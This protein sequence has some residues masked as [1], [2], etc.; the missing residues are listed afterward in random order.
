ME[1]HVYSAKNLER[2]KL[3]LQ[4]NAKETIKEKYKLTL[5]L[6]PRLITIIAMIKFNIATIKRVLFFKVKFI[7]ISIIFYIIYLGKLSPSKYIAVIHFYS[8]KIGDFCQ[9]SWVMSTTCKFMFYHYY[10]TL[11]N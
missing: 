4:K 3:K 10:F 5:F 2:N 8:S 6:Y 11:P 7:M 1:V 9:G